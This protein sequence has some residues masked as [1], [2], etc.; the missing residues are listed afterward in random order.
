MLTALD[1]C[2]LSGMCAPDPAITLVRWH[3][4][5]VKRVL[6]LNVLSIFFIVLLYFLWLN[7]QT[8]ES[9]IFLTK[10]AIDY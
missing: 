9:K 8:I 10:Q 1:E 3:F 4:P 2:E 5:T 6:K 7:N